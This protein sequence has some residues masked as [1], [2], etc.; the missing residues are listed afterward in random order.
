[1]TPFYA[2][3]PFLEAATAFFPLQFICTNTQAHKYDFT[4]AKQGHSMYST[5]AGFLAKHTWS[6]SAAP[7]WVTWLSPFGWHQTWLFD[8]WYLAW[9]SKRCLSHVFKERAGI[10]Q[11]PARENALHGTPARLFFA[12]KRQLTDF[13]THFIFLPKQLKWSEKQFRE[14]HLFTFLP[15][16]RRG[17]R[18]RSYVLFVT[19]EATARRCLA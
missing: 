4:S 7:T 5:C 6:R 3:R 9:E 15:R 13:K 18:Y 2:S 17:Y 1:M 14:M 10:C 8:Q 16:V 11:I 12:L 19:Y